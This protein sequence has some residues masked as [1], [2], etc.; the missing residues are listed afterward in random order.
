MIRIRIRGDGMAEVPNINKQAFDEVAKIAKSG[1]DRPVLMLNLNT[2]FHGQSTMSSD[3]Y[4]AYNSAVEAILRE[5]KGKILWR[6]P[7]Y[8]QPVGKQNVDEVLA[9]WYPNHQA[10]IDIKD[11]P[12]SARFAEAKNRVVKHAIIH[13]S[14]PYT[15]ERVP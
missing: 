1:D 13:R 3:A 6:S 2:Y 5:V 11:A 10:F 12:S 7:V 14:D 8:G 4:K 9:V 15:I